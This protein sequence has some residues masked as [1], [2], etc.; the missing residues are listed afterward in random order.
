MNSV[1][2]FA[3]GTG[4]GPV[5][6]LCKVLKKLDFPKVQGTS[7]LDDISRNTLFLELVA[8]GFTSNSTDPFLRY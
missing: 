3:L 1:S 5:M 4:K 8:T 7:S 6:G 2:N